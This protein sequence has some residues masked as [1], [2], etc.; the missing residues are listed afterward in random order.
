MKRFMNKILIVV[1]LLCAVATVFIFAAHNVNAKEKETV[2]TDK[3][4]EKW[5]HD[6][7]KM[8]KKF[9]VLT[10][11][12]D[13]YAEK[14]ESDEKIKK[15]YE[16]YYNTYGKK[17]GNNTVEQFKKAETYVDVCNVLSKT[18]MDWIKNGK[19]A[20]HLDNGYQIGKVVLK[21]ASYCLFGAAGG[22]VTESALAILDNVTSFGESSESEIEQLQNHLDEKFDEVD[23]HLD[24]LQRDLSEVSKQ[25]DSQT[26][27]IVE[28][29]SN[30]LEATYA[31]Q[32]VS[33]FMTSRDG[34]F[35]YSLFKEYLYAS[36][37]P[38]SD[39][40]SQN[41]YYYKLLK[42]LSE[43]S[44]DELIKDAF[45]N[46]Y[47]YINA[48]DNRAEKTPTEKLYDY[49]LKDDYG[50]ESIQY[51]FYE[52]LNT[53]SSD[54]D[55]EVPA[56]E[57]FN[58]M[59]DLYET[60]LM[61]DFC[62][63][64]CNAYQVLN[65]KSYNGELRYYYGTGDNDY[66]TYDDVVALENKIN[67]REEALL[68]QILHDITVFFRVGDSYSVETANGDYRICLNNGA[69][70]FGN[71]QKND[72]IYLNK[73]VDRWCTLFGLDLQDFEYSFDSSNEHLVSSDGSYKVK[74]ENGSMFVANVSYRGIN[75]Y[76]INFT[77]GNNS[78]FNGGSGTED[79]PY[80]ISDPD[81]FLLL[82]GIDGPKEDCYELAGN[83]N[84]GGI[85]LS[86]IADELNKF[87]GS[88]DGNG[89]TIYN[90]II[91]DDVSSGL[92]GYIGEDGI[93]SNLN[94]ANC[95][96]NANSSDNDK[97]YA[98]A[99]AG[100]NEGTINNCHLLN[101]LNGE[102]IG[103]C[104]I[105]AIRNTDKPNKSL[106]T[107]AGGI[108]GMNY[109][110]VTYCSID[111][112]D[113]VS[114]S[115]F[116]YQSNSDSKNK[117]FV[118]AG[119]IF[120]ETCGGSV[121]NCYIGESVTLMAKGHSECKD[122][123]A[124]RHPYIEV[125]SG[126]LGGEVAGTANIKDIYSLIPETNVKCATYRINNQ[127]SGVSDE[128]NIK[129]HHNPLIAS[130]K[131]SQNDEISTS[132]IDDVTLAS[133][134]INI[135]V[136]YYNAQTKTFTDQVLDQVY[137]YGEQ[138]FRDNNI[139]IEVN[140]EIE[141]YETLGYY[142]FETKK[143]SFEEAGGIRGYSDVETTVKMLIYID[144]YDTIK[145]IEIPIVIEKPK[146]EKLEVKT[147][148]NKTEYDYT[149]LGC[150]ISLE[151]ASI[152]I[153]Y[154]DGYEEEVSANS[155]VG[156]LNANEASAEIV[157]VEF[158][159]Y[160]SVVSNRKQSVEVSCTYKGITYT[161]KFDV[162]IS[163][164]HNWTHETVDAT[165]EH[166]GY[167]SHVCEKCGAIYKDN[168]SESRLPHEAVIYNYDSV[169]ARSIEGYVGYKDSTCTAYGYTGD[170]YCTHCHKIVE[171]GSV[172]DLKNHTYDD[173]HCNGV[174]HVCLVCGHTEQHFFSTTECDDCVE[175]ECIY[176]HY[177]HT[178]EANSRSA[179]ENLPHIT[180]TNTYALP[181]GENVV[182]FVELHGN[183][184]ITSAYL[185]IKYPE[186]LTLVSYSLGNV[187]NKPDI[188]QFREY[189]DHLNVQLSHRD[190]EQSKN[191]TLL[192]LVFNLPKGS[193]VGDEFIIEVN[194]DEIIVEEI[195]GLF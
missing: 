85:T 46:L 172:I 86:P 122:G 50:S 190:A 194:D 56:F 36:A 33:K 58:F 117:Q 114:E 185:S 148:P 20:D 43:D 13:A 83:L 160:G 39:D 38:Q 153:V 167:T 178:Y 2:M 62:I 193:V 99:I 52:F 118:Y 35:D 143:T 116:D 111:N 48:T 82:F 84:M 107:Y 163:C 124:W 21:I 49:L 88:F 67:N 92:F 152:K 104:S 54:L 175:A 108:V 157:N 51:Y 80:I 180:I 18:I 44:S 158:D 42:V 5:F 23:F 147:L 182:V 141:L 47:K 37:N 68:E 31:K 151:G 145:T 97:L 165:C 162:T 27:E 25:I 179:I 195:E 142:G 75:L 136:V 181:E 120:G 14:L 19:N 81:Q 156:K 12:V 59:Y 189:N 110:T 98:G 9:K 32:E 130:Y 128:V 26:K 96:F 69:G 171:K 137:S 3:Q 159:D 144:E 119:G 113:V 109:G 73:Y 79:D 138:V 168:Y 90:L 192:K 115:Y 150:D 17:I 63:R 139:F 123:L 186:E 7:D 66:I 135:S 6:H 121:T 100:Q 173:I 149:E 183:E 140:G 177:K 71:V 91:D 132:N 72:T 112:S 93:V 126:G 78:T 70:T 103:L 16:K 15:A 1:F 155:V 127:W 154:E 11:E 95:S 94:L 187:L 166:L 169:E 161:T 34:N 61:A 134:D 57:A 131:K 129:E 40:Y 184:G 45:D 106:Y 22:I 41:A 60:A 188:E 125:F 76:S 30:A 176:C 29:L 28:R 170:V 77:V 24:E 53:N 87:N 4:V 164:A 65:M 64:Y 133:D 105:G 8:E 146:P 174:E 102:V 101:K 74:L 191:G 55:F 89:Y 10:S